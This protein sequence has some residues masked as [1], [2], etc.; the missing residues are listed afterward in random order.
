MLTVPGVLSR[1]P[2]LRTVVVST[3]VEALRR[4]LLSSD[5]PRS[6][7]AM[8]TPIPPPNMRIDPAAVKWRCMP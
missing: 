5:E 6:R 2:P 7:S 3:F 8:R 1:F 4:Q